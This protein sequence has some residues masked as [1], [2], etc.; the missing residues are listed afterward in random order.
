MVKVFISSTKQDLTAYRQ[1]AIETCNRL[2]LI[3]FAMEFF[4]AEGLDGTEG[5]K[6][7]LDEANVYVG[8]FAHRYGEVTQAEF[9]Y[10]GE[11]GIERL[12][13]V[14]DPTY[15][16]SVESIDH[17]REKIENFKRRLQDEVIRGKFTTVDNFQTLLMHALVEW[18]DRNNVE[19]KSAEPPADV[20]P[21]LERQRPQRP[22]LLVG[23]DADAQ[24]IKSRLGIPTEEQRKPLT[25]IRGWPGVGKTTLINA[26]IYDPEVTAEF[27]DGILWAVLGE[28][29][30]PFSELTSWGR[31]LGIP[32][33]INIPTL[34]AA[35]ERIRAVLGNKKILLI[36]DDVWKADDANP[37]IQV[38]GNNCAILVSTRF[39]EVA[40]GLA[41]TPDN[42]YRLKEL[43]VEPAFELLSRLTPQVAEKYPNETR[44][45]V[46]DLEGLPLAIRVAG[47]LLDEE[48][49]LGF[50]VLPLLKEI[51]ESHRLLDEVAPDDR[52]DPMSG[53]TPTINLVIKRSVDCLDKDA[54]GCFAM[55]GAFAP[56]PATFDLPAM[57]FIWEKEDGKPMVH[58]L[59]G[60]GLL[61]P[62]PEINRFQMHAVLV[63][64]AQSLLDDDGDG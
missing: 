16:W 63:M 8:I 11:R 33:I 5:S 14:V 36:A 4:E 48:N 30:N 46:T 10:A 17:N 27:T 35:M 9:D 52:F 64:Y 60:R 44:T 18:R 31:Q 42:I 1:A 3:P 47:R 58:K 34:E 62:I 61:E 12:C 55:L 40:R 51:R 38:T 22:A 53:T 13:F 50:P 23:R 20:P 15:V 26:L 56:K 59:V 19:V 54:Q 25:I 41:S 57:E 43:D 6:R 39:P 49:A 7:Q 28:N 21:S 24:N 2:H 45:L 32:D 37:L 29:A